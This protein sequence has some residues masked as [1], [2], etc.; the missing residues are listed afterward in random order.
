MLF[1]VVASNVD[2]SRFFAISASSAA[3][4]LSYVQKTIGTGYQVEV[5]V[6]ET[7]IQAQ[8]GHIAELATT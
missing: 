1:G 7:L 6:L 3:L 5:D 8:Y 2:E 4:A